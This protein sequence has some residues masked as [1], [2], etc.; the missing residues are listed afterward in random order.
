MEPMSKADKVRRGE[1]CPVCHEWRRDWLVWRRG[2]VVCQGCGNHYVPG[3]GKMPRQLD[4]VRTIRGPYGTYLCAAEYAAHA[5][6]MEEICSQWLGVRVM[7]GDEKATIIGIVSDQVGGGVHPVILID[8]E[9][10]PILLA[11]WSPSD[12]F[13]SKKLCERCEVTPAG[14]PK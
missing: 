6:Y 7:H 4:E 11:I 10:R 9:D 14:M 1:E 12:Y 8:G 13:S 2:E 5:A 3:G